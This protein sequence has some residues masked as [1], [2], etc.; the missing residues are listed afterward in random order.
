[1]FTAMIRVIYA[2]LLCHQ[3]DGNWCRRFLRIALEINLENI[4]PCV[5][6]CG[7]RN[8]SEKNRRTYIFV[9]LP[10]SR[11]IENKRRLHFQHLHQVKLSNL[12]LSFFNIFSRSNSVFYKQNRLAS[13]KSQSLRTVRHARRFLRAI[14]KRSVPE[15]TLNLDF[16]TD[17]LETRSWVVVSQVL[18]GNLGSILPPDFPSFFSLLPPPSQE[19]RWI[20]S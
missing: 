2:L 7:K 15:K 9:N 19:S 17:F 18:G 13:Q 16:Q 4:L 5:R 3:P 10:S 1:M 6:A 8:L 11:S 14:G 12:I 20:L